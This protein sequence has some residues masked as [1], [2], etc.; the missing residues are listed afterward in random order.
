MPPITS[1]VPV[2]S[3]ARIS[4][5]GERDEHGVTDQHRVNRRTA[6]RLGFHVVAEMTDNDRSASK[7]HV[8]REAFEEMLKAI[9]VGKLADGTPVQGV[10]VLNEDRLARRAGD[11]ERFVEALTAEDGRVFADERGVKDL[12]AEDVEGMGLVGVAFSKIES[13]KVRRRMKRF[14][15][16]RAEDG[17][18]AGGTRPFGWAE[19]RINLHPVEAPLLEK[20]AKDFAAGRSMNSIVREWVRDGVK[21][22][23]GNDWTAR[24][25]R[26]TLA[27]PRLCGWR[28]LHG[29]I[30]KD[31][32]GQPIVGEWKPIID[33]DTWQAIDAI[34]SARKGR[35]VSPD[36]TIGDVLTADFAEHKYLL[37]GILRCGKPKADGALCYA[38]LRARRVGGPNNVYHYVC[39]P[40]AQGG[41]AGIGRDGRKTD[42]YISE[43]VLAK[44]EQREMQAVG[45]EQ[46]AGE[47]E[48]EATQRQ[49]D[50]L[51]REWRAGGISNEFFFTNVRHLEEKLARLRAGQGRHAAQRKRRSLDIEDVRRRWYA[52]EEDGGFDVAQKRAYVREALHAVIV[53]PGRPGRAP[54]NPDLLQPIWRED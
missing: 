33:P 1:T 39:P 31:D 13:R 46:W 11:Y 29:E 25:L 34:M 27:N 53:H 9:T 35:K 12:Y 23:L 40:K 28:R 5:D 38:P 36:G 54:F 16:A 19:D 37:S 10:V 2:I 26:V 52:A 20:A 41:C 50:D 4:S 6:K 45:E 47:P 48:L 51:G 42:E 18:P 14:H 17:K 15:R 43:A 32:N 24:S 30:V 3:Y 44:L 8:V 21:T 49:L 22:S 7:A